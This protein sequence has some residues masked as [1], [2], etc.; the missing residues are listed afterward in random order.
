[1]AEE[2]ATQ[3]LPTGAIVVQVGDEVRVLWD[4]GDGLGWAWYDADE[5]QLANLMGDDW[6]DEIFE[7]MPNESSF[8]TKYGD[9]YWGN[10]AEIDLRADTPWEDLQESVYDAFGP[11]SGM[12]TPEIKRLI[13]QGY[14]ES[15]DTNQFLVHYRD[16]HYYQSLNDLQRAW[17]IKSEAE[18]QSLIEA[19]AGRLLESYRSF[20]GVDPAGGLSELYADAERIASGNLSRSTWEYQTRRAAEAVDDTP[21]A[22]D[23]TEEE[24]A[25]GEEEVTIENLGAYIAEQYRLWLGPIEVDKGFQQYWAKNMYMNKLSEADLEAELKLIA[26]G[27]YGEFKP[28]NVTWSAWAAPWKGKINNLLETQIADDDLLLD[29]ILSNGMTGREATL[30]IRKD[31]RFLN[32]QTMLNELSEATADLGRQFGFVA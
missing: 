2:E 22:R 26:N 21:A 28:E 24:R 3:A 8:K 6:E 10:V 14:F 23:V 25:R 12:D 4:L 7:V 19:E 31:K 16:S 30:A 5:E 15:W 29:T 13:L 32:T 27:L 17:S 18:R 20:W 1:M 9:Y 11:I